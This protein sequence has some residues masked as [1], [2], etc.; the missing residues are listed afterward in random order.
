MDLLADQPLAFT[1]MGVVAGKAFCSLG[2]ETGMTGQGIGLAMTTQTELVTVV[3]KK[4]VVVSMVGLMTGHTIAIA[5]GLMPYRILLACQ[6]LMAAETTLGNGP[7]QQSLMVRGMGAVTGQALPFPDR[8]MLHP[9]AKGLFGLI[10]TGIA[11]I[12]SLLLEQPLE[13][14][15]MGIMA[16]GA[17]VLGHRPMNKFSAEL[18]LGMAA[19]AALHGPGRIIRDHKQETNRK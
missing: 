9:L 1:A 10:M 17:L 4:L 5:K 15:D 2:R 3:L 14:S 13:F 16:L 19:N 7:A 11:E 6:G 12:T 8:L 18:L